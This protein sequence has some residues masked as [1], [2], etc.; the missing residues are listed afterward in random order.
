MKP[1]KKTSKEAVLKDLGEITSGVFSAKFPGT[2]GLTGLKIKVGDRI[3]YPSY[4]STKNGSPCHVAALHY[5]L[6]FPFIITTVE[7]LKVSSLAPEQKIELMEII[8][9]ERLALKKEKGNG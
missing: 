7:G 9:S 8:E 5:R 1:S 6:W 2:C 4:G 3:A